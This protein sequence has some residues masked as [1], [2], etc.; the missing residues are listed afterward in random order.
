MLKQL[1]LLIF[2]IAL[3]YSSYAQCLEVLDGNGVFDDIQNLFP[4]HRELTPYLFSQIETWGTTPLYG[5]MV[6][7]MQ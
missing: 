3:G 6:L 5:E 2:S 7:L 4:V 1:L